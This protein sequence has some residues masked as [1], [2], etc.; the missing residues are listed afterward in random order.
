[1]IRDGY[2]QFWDLGAGLNN[3]R[4]SLPGNNGGWPNLITLTRIFTNAVALGQPMPVQFYYQWAQPGTSLATL[5][6]YL[7]ADANPLNTN[8]ILLCNIA[9]PGTGAGSVGFSATNLLLTAT[10]VVPGPYSVLGK[11]TAGAQSRFLYAPQSVQVLAPSAPPTLDIV[12]LT[13]T[14]FRIGVNAQSGQTVVLESS[15]DLQ[16]WLP[17]ATN[18]MTSARWDYTNS[19]APGLEANYYRALTP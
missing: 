18:V 8:Q 7:D 16:S 9:L 2:N 15:P 5:D 3:N 19:P 12:K 17:L 11:L 13:A 6:I 14:N 1:M 4:T 10:N